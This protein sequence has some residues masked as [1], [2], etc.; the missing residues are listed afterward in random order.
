MSQ[1]QG[2][3]AGNDYSEMVESFS[4][5]FEMQI[6]PWSA[7]ITF[8]SRS[9]KQGEDHKYTVRVRMPLQQA[10]A[11]GVLM[12]RNVRA[13]EEQTGADIDLPRQVLE[14]LN[15]PPED[16]VRFKDS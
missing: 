5:V 16:W 9:L 14:S 1:Q 13:Y 2:T 12:L 10:K 3:P 6:T 15:I 7:A 11:L 4:D 8:G